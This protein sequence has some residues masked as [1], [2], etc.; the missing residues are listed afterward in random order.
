MFSMCWLELVRKKGKWTS[1]ETLGKTDFSC[2][3]C[4][5]S[6]VVKNKVVY[7]GEEWEEATFVLKQTKEEG[8]LE[9]KSS[10]S[11]IN[12][13][14]GYSDSSFCTYRE[15]IYY[16]PKDK[17]SQVWCLDAESEQAILYFSM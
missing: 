6:T 13:K 5:D 1:V 9:L 3:Y 7:F 2:H 15:K 14:R 17:V 8:S 11:E 10:F 16:F 4:R 12:Y